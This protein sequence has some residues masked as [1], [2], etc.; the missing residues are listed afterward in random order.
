MPRVGGMND[1]YIM[2]LG[3]DASFL[4]VGE[5]KGIQQGLKKKPVKE[6]EGFETPDKL[7]RWSWR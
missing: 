3:E 7:R 5:E 6:G 4:K 1:E 2:D